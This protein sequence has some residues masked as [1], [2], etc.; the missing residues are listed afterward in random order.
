MHRVALTVV[1]TALVAV[2]GCAGGGGTGGPGGNGAPAQAA[3]GSGGSGGGSVGVSVGGA[4]DANAFRKNVRNGYVPQPTDLTYE[5]LFHD[6]YFDTGR[7]EPCEAK[8]CPSY[9]VAVTRDPLS[10]ETERF[11]TVGLN[12]GLSKA[13][14]ERKPLNLVVVVDTSGS[15]SEQFDE[16]YYDG[17]E[18]KTVE[19]N[20]PKM[21]AAK[22]A[23]VSMLDQLNASDR[24]AVVGYDDDASVVQDLQRVGETDVADLRSDV[25]DLRADGGTNLDA[26]MRTAHRLVA[27][28]GSDSGRETR[29]VYVTDAMPNVGDTGGESLK[30]RLRSHASEGV[31]STFVGVGVDFNSRLTEVVAT[32]KGANY[33]SVH[34]PA[35]F[36]ERM[37]E[38]FSY[39]V[40]P[41]AYN[42]SLSVV[43][44]GYEIETVYGSPQDDRANAT[45]MSV[46]TLF[47]SRR[48]G[49]KTEGGVVLLE[50]EKQRE[51]ATFRVRA[52]YEDTDGSTRAVNRTVGF[53]DHDPPYYGSSGVRKAVAL[54]EYGTL[55]RNWMVHERASASGDEAPVPAEGGAIE[56]RQFDSEWEQTSVDLRVSGPYDER[57]RRFLPY[58][59]AQKR[60]LGAERMAKDLAILRALANETAESTGGSGD[61][62]TGGDSLTGETGDRRQAT[63]TTT[64]AGGTS[65]AGLLGAGDVGPVVGVL[66]LLLTV[67]VAAYGI[68]QKRR[69]R[70][71]DP[72]L[73]R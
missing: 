56:H 22:E 44:D 43:G 5:G 27:D 49:N 41:L 19:E 12:S 1:V 50:V 11:V 39:M 58:F 14:F 68:K 64:P 37:D 36:D 34:S 55:M 65:S 63:A 16:Y 18:R 23:V 53:A 24:V 29:V 15:M 26:G 73:R 62:T 6:Y 38:S 40:T 28:R 48:E 4:Q 45:L 72:D 54:A 70:D 32:V 46:R 30:D 3:G 20:E 61:G 51:D 67:A 69:S 2:A 10:N 21:A 47:P 52:S 17:G 71:A 9:S 35:E 8:F 13:D 31:H 66:N 25:R 57:I 60:T 33:Y 7:R 59:R 42:L